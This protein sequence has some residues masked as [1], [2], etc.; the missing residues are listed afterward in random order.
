MNR[1]NYF[2]SYSSKDDNHE[3]QLTRA[4]LVLLKHSSHTFFS[5]LEYCRCKQII[6][7]SEKPISFLEILEDSWE[8]ETQ[9][10]N[11]EIKTNYL[12]SILITDSNPE[13]KISVQSSDR[14]ARYDGV[15]TFGDKITMIIEN[16]PRSGNV[17]FEQLNPSRQNLADGT[18]IYSNPIILEWKEIIKHLNQLLNLQ[19]ISGGEKLLIEDFLYFIDDNFAYLNPFDSF[20]QCKGN[21]EG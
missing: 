4:Y 14:N 16:K 19:T 7:D 18:M 2:N 8:I 6:S 1:L 11:P 10:G 12:L 5:F 9:K 13:N 20:H 3:D 15:L 21:I 17:W